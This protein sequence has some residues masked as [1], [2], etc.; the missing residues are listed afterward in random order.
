MSRFSLPRYPIIQA[1]MA[2]GITTVDL[3]TAV[4][5]A[6]AVGSFGF[7]YST[8]DVIASDLAQCRAGTDGALLA[9]FFVVEEPAE[10]S[11][12]DR[13]A[14]CAA[15]EALA[16]KGGVYSQPQP[17][18][19]MDLTAQLAPI[20]KQPPTYL[21]FHFGV[22]SQ[23]I[24]ARAH[25]L[26][27][28]VGIS[29]TNVSEAKEIA[30]AGADFIIA[31]G[32]E[33]GGHRGTFEAAPLSDEALSTQALT[34]ALAKNTS[35]PIVAAGGIMTASHIKEALAAGAVAVQ[36]GTAFLAADEAGTAPS[37]R[38]ALC[39]VPCRATVLT[40]HFSGRVARSLQNEFIT[41]M[42]GQ[43]YL[44]FPIQNRM[45]G[46]LRSA[47]AKSGTAE[48]QSLWAGTG[49]ADISQGPAAKILAELCAEL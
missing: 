15:L 36:M 35:L 26:G 22:P 24:L 14:A 2:G 16:F 10:P 31:Q 13:E 17:P 34:S 42:A 37:Y 30:A 12:A 41:R 21:T 3:V 23:D 40:P 19:I 47:A 49:V 6:G 45:T 7:A 20:W 5:N 9:N 25:A 27:I 46:P 29:A 33:A 18:Y 28:A 48:Y 39:E 11:Q 4:A 38:D 44:P 8:A 43:P 32:I 1:P